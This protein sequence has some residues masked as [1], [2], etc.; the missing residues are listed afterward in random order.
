MF[1]YTSNFISPNEKRTAM[2]LLRFHSFFFFLTFARAVDSYRIERISSRISAIDR[3]LCTNSRATVAN[4]MRSI[5]FYVI[6]FIFGINSLID[7]ISRF[8]CLSRR[9]VLFVGVS[10]FLVEE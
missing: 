2:S 10:G 6:D 9:R 1:I 3:V 5:I 8:D 4:Y 7:M